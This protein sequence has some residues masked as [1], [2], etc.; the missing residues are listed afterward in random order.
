M[1]QITIEP[2]TPARFDD[3]QHALT[4]GGDGRHCQC[5]WWTITNAQFNAL[6]TDERR[7]LLRDEIESGPPPALI[8]YVDGEAAGW[9]RVGP[10]TAQV[11]LSRTKRF[12]ASE[13]PWDDET[14]WAVTCFVV[15]KEQRGVGLN[16]RLLDAALAFARDGG[17][18]VVE[19]YPV[20]PAL[21]RKKSSNDLYHG[22]VS[23]FLSA[24][25]RE[26]ARPSPDR[27]IMALDLST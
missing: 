6:S 21:G 16:A 15:R 13:E 22:V 20:D 12:A 27:P 11:R 3:A 2:A 9:V 23:T 19:A 17:A 25:F 14:V 8:A 24:G 4:G 10:R 18:R 7:E 26:V 1:A 5:Q